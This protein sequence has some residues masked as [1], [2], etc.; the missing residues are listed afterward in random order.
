M[1]IGNF[2]LSFYKKITCLKCLIFTEITNY[3]MGFQKKYTKICIV[4]LTF[5]H[6]RFLETWF[7]EF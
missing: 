4:I 1:K 5:D 3:W 6:F 7:P 2:L